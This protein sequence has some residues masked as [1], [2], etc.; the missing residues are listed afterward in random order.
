MVYPNPVNNQ[1]NIKHSGAKGSM[2]V[3]VLDMHGKICQEVLSVQTETT[4]NIEALAP[5]VYLVRCVLENDV[6]V[7][8]K[9][10]KN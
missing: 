2:V 5:G 10:V 3:Q 6:V 8:T 9:V 1:L 4:I 7:N